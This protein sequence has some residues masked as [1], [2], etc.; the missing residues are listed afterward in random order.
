MDFLQADLSTHDR[1]RCTCNE[2]QELKAKF[3]RDAIAAHLAITPHCSAC[4]HWT[5][6]D[7]GEDDIDIGT[8]VLKDHSKTAWYFSCPRFDRRDPNSSQTVDAGRT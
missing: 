4:K 8:C 1:L 5:F 3:E 6:Y 2:C 7:Y